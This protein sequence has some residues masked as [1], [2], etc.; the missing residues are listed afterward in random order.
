MVSAIRN[1]LMGIVSLLIITP[2]II[3]VCGFIWVQIPEKPQP[4]S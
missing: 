1:D 2:I 4:Y 3:L